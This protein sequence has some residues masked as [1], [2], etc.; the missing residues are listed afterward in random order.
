MGF[1]MGLMLVDTPAGI[2]RGATAGRGKLRASLSS[3][4]QSVM[5][6]AVRSCWS[7]LH[8]GHWRL[9]SYC[10]GSL[11]RRVGT[12]VEVI[13]VVLAWTL[14]VASSTSMMAGERADEDNGEMGIL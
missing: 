4:G 11:R 6:V 7:Y 2:S 8:I 5:I 10:L 13:L 14:S 1:T 3:C 12:S 9:R